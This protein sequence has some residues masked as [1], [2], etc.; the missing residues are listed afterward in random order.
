MKRPTET[1]A[2]PLE[3][4]L[5]ELAAHLVDVTDLRLPNL[6]ASIRDVRGV[7]QKA[8]GVLSKLEHRLIHRK[9]KK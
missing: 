7:C 4:V 5:A 2:E 1:R 3:Q 9:H 8:Y 6:E